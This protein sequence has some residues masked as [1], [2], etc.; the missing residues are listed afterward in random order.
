MNRKNKMLLF[1]IA[2]GFFVLGDLSVMAQSGRFIEGRVYLENRTVAV[3]PFVNLERDDS[4]TYLVDLIVETLHT[5]LGKK[6][7]IRLV[8]RSQVE[9]LLREIRFSGK[10]LV[11]PGT[12]LRIGRM[13]AAQ[14][15][16]IGSFHQHGKSIRIN[17]RFVEVETGRIGDSAVVTGNKKKLVLSH[18]V[19]VW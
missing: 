1:F 14:V 15:V 12:A 13:L 7:G 4:K 8:E 6:K 10:T 17:G 9:Q 16:V 3:L 18:I 11:D 5:V 2:L 19:W